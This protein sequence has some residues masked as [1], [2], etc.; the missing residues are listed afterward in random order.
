MS[1]SKKHFSKETREQQIIAASDFVLKEVG[2]NLNVELLNS[3]TN[4]IEHLTLISFG[5]TILRQVSF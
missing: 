1:V 3:T 4:K 5:K 2:A